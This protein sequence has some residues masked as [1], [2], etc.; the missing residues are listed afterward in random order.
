MEDAAEK[1]KDL[2]K[3]NQ[4]SIHNL[5]IELQKYHHHASK[6]A[7]VIVGLQEQ[8]EKKSAEVA[9]N[10]AKYMAVR[11]LITCSTVS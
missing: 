1:Q 2:V 8:S 7:K 10:A 5:E 11:S 4:V 6:Q 9:A 3:I